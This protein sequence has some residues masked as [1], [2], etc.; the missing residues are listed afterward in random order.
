M[1]GNA[2]LHNFLFFIY[3]LTCIVCTVD[4]KL[5]VYPS[6]SR[7]LLMEISILC[8]TCLVMYHAVFTG[9]YNSSFKPNVIH[10]FVIF[11]II[12]IL[13]HNLQL[14]IVE[15]YRTIYLCLT[16]FAIF[17]LSYAQSTKLLN[18]KEIEFGLILIAVLH[19]IYILGQFLGVIKSDNTYFK[20]T[21]CNENPSVTAIYLTGCIPLIV[22]RIIDNKHHFFYIFV[23]SLSL[24]S[25]ILLHCRTAYLGLCIESFVLL[26]QMAR[27]HNNCR[28]V[29]SKYRTEITF[30]VLLIAIPV[31]IHTYNMKR[32]SSDSRWLIWKLSVQMIK[33]KPQ[34]YGYGLFEK[35][36]NQK[37][38]AYF[39]SGSGTL[40]EQRTASFCNMAYNDYLEQ[41]VEG[42]VIGLYFIFT[43]Y[44]LLAIK[45][46]RNN[47]TE[48]LCLSC[49]FA[50]M[51]LT[52]FVYSSIQPWWLLVCC[53]SIVST[54]RNSVY[55]RRQYSIPL[56]VIAIIIITTTVIKVGRMALSQLELRT[57]F[58]AVARG[59]KVM[60]DKLRILKIRIG[61]SEAY[62]NTCAYNSILNNKF[63]DAIKYLDKACLYTSSKHC[64]I[65]HYISYKNIGME[66]KGIQ[67]IDTLC[68]VQPS[69]LRPKLIL[70]E[71]YDKISDTPKALIY[72]NEILSTTPRIR[73]RESSHIQLKALEL[74]KKT[75]QEEYGKLH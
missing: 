66:N 56:F 38:A 58:N 43:F 7:S 12:F 4:T 51:S 31:S 30:L 50:I 74:L 29:I 27:Y 23:L 26:L 15:E 6:L 13:A 45:S 24:F 69:L 22:K 37:Q 71:Y 48:I 11:W 44:V 9:K 35:Y 62:W 14:D 19:L 25:I 55:L 20:L 68:Y 42:G 61:T 41:G 21:G 10:I 40:E 5:F 70:M 75:N 72:A 3:L 36:Y 60:D 54:Q 65:A 47:D 17:P 57:Y 67:Y 32:D 28:H 64:Y 46:I 2:I 16:L 53:A 59:E 39:R 49:G 18:R 8:I 63:D 33:D 1:N 34:G 73:N 52:N